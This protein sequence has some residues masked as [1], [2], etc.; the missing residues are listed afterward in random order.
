M[1][2]T[3]FDSIS[4]KEMDAK[5]QTKT[6]IAGIAKRKKEKRVVVL[7]WL[8]LGKAFLE[9]RVEFGGGCWEE[10]NKSV[11]SDQ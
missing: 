4:S 6:P 1:G 5:T 7:L 8:D 3:L 9:K 10:E 2:V 11:W